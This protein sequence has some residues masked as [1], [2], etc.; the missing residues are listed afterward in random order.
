MAKRP[1][2]LRDH[3]V[4]LAPFSGPLHHRLYLAMREKIL[5]GEMPPGERLPSSRGLA[6]MLGLSRN[7]VLTVYDRLSDEGYVVAKV[8]CG[9]HV[10]CPLARPRPTFLAAVEGRKGIGRF[11][12]ILQKSHYPLRFTSFQD[13]HGNL[14]YLYD[15]GQFFW[16]TGN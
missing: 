12:A 10:K 6:R 16:T 3:S 15:A 5:S 7:T 11:A 4:S 1:P 14:L 9:T 13:C 8:G 2:V